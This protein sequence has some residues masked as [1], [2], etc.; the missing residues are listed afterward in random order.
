[1]RTT[2]QAYVGFRHITMRA[3]L[4]SSIKEDP[5]VPIVPEFANTNGESFSQPGP[6]KVPERTVEGNG[7]LPVGL[8]ALSS[9]SCHPAA[10]WV[11]PRSGLHGDHAAADVPARRRAGVATSG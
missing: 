3:S 10:S 8:G 9:R 1:M 5:K 6:G 2:A 4:V 11:H 7:F